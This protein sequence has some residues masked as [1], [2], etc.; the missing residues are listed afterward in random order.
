L[1]FILAIIGCVQFII[2]TTVAM[3]F[4]PGGTYTD[5]NATGYSFW[6]NFFSDL[7]RIE[8]FL[9]VSNTVS[10]SLFTTALSFAGLV[11]ILAF[12]ALPQLFTRVKAARR[13]AVLGS[14]FGIISAISYLGIASVPS[15]F[16][17]LTHKL[18]VYIGFTSFL[19]VVAL[20]S[21]AIFRSKY[22]PRA[23]AFTYL[24]FAV[25]L[26]LYLV[27][28]FAGPKAETALGDKIQ[29]TGQKIVVYAEI[30]CMFIQSY[31][32]LQ[33]QKRLQGRGHE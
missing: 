11:L 12:A 21:A 15:D 26:A 8:T 24:G 10:R 16:H 30:V 1:A 13:L 19:L 14:I 18:F 23:Y 20:Y 25:I 27:L 17:L 31:G 2:L 5:H 9:G 22:Y 3:F 33:V 32:A 6:S 29:A 28:L 4:Y 7:G